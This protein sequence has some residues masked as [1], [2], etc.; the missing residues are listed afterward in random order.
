MATVSALRRLRAQGARMAPLLD[1]YDV[2]VSPVSTAPAPELGFLGPDVPF[3]T[4]FARVRDY[5]LF[6]PLQ[7]VTGDPAISLPL[8]MSTSGL[9]I[10]VQFIAGHGREATL[11]ELAYELEADG[12]FSR[13]AAAAL[14]STAG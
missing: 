10:G 2:L 1:R 13:P 8:G 12:A 7:N 11:L 6:T 14:A 3:A 5:F 9:P 4:A